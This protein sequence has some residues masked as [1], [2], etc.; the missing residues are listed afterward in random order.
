[1]AVVDIV[2]ENG[3]RRVENKAMKKNVGKKMKVLQ[4]GIENVRV[5]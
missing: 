2:N 1:V 3:V 4:K 5:L